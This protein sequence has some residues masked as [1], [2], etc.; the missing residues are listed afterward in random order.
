[1][2]TAV[3]T[4]SLEA[5]A[6]A[7]SEATGAL[8]LKHTQG[9]LRGRQRPVA[10][11]AVG[12]AKA[13]Q[14]KSERLKEKVRD[15]TCGGSEVQTTQTAHTAEMAAEAVEETT[16]DPATAGEWWWRQ[17]VDATEAIEAARMKKAAHH[18]DS[19]SMVEAVNW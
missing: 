12:S 1:M 2:E 4:N 5:A 18:R 7:V 8:K 3:A 6:L 11:A 9:Q 10:T 19:S 16:V 17:P 14:A 15:T 13:I